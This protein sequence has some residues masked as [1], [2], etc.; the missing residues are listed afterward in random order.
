MTVYPYGV[1]RRITSSQVAFQV[2]AK[3]QHL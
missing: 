1:M 3:V 2:A